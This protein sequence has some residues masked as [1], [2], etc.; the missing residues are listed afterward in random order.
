MNARKS[1]GL[2]SQV[3]HFLGYQ[4]YLGDIDTQAEELQD[5]G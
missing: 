3:P 1:Y 5:S 2:S 4:P